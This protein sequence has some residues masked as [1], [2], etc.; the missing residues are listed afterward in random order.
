MTEDIRT[1]DIVKGQTEVRI[2]KYGPFL[3]HEHIS[4]T[5]NLPFQYGKDRII[6]MVRDPWWIF[7]YW[8]ITPGR[9]NFI[10][11]KII[12]KGQ[13]IER[14]VLRVYNITGIK[15]FDGR[16]ANSYF[17]IALK[18]MARNWYIDVGS[19]N[20]SW[21]VEIGIVSEESD[22]Y[23]LAR[24]NTVRTPP[25]G[26]SDILDES[27]MMSEDDYYKI[28]GV[29]CGFDVIGKSSLE[30]KELFYKHLRHWISSG[31]VSS[32]SCRL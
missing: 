18:D 30:M 11:E 17:D 1:N 20:N 4:R 25:F 19:P 26:I 23:M 6:T 22:F 12:K 8:E 10:K 31:G 24:S 15:D 9:E 32:Y 5:I 2:S 3:E 13:D 7:V 21:C 27:W 16:N 28:A 14:S 29:S